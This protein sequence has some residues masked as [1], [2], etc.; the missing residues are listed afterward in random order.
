MCTTVRKQFPHHTASHVEPR[1]VQAHHF[2]AFKMKER[3]SSE[4]PS[5]SFADPHPLRTDEDWN[6]THPDQSGASLS[7]SGQ[8]S[9]PTYNVDPTKEGHH[10]PSVCSNQTGLNL[11]GAA[12]PDNLAA[13][14]YG[15]TVPGTSVNHMLNETSRARGK[16]AASPAD[17]DPNLLSE[18]IARQNRWS[19]HAGIGLSRVRKALRQVARP[20]ER[21]VSE[22]RS[23]TIA[24]LE[25]SILPV[26]ANERSIRN[27]PP[28]VPDE[29]TISSII[30]SQRTATIA[31]C[32]TLNGQGG[33]P[34][35][36]IQ[37]ADQPVKSAEDWRTDVLLSFCEYL[38]PRGQLSDRKRVEKIQIS[39]Q[40]IK[41]GKN[42]NDPN[43]PDIRQ[44]C[45][46]RLRPWV[47]ASKERGTPWWHPPVSFPSSSAAIL[48]ALPVGALL[49]ELQWRACDQCFLA[50]GEILPRR[51]DTLCATCYCD[52]SL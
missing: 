43:D 14:G 50:T 19:Q 11:P 23:I 36:S 5:S 41:V 35:T 51:S 4:Y 28:P 45:T 52:P 9:L 34:T 3:Y 24:A 39:I 37:G 46:G 29:H 38:Y 27:P 12:I 20:R 6:A 33:P 21:S 49:S 18:T 31:S 16:T 13:N 30:A 17:D 15:L 10:P 48:R 47:Q 7:L 44:P 25:A 32:G 2:R 42:L 1:S 40:R 26:P 8:E 22:M